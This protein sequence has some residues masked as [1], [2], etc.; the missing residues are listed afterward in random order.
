M[1]YLGDIVGEHVH[2]IHIR[3]EE[4]KLQTPSLLLL[5]YSQFTYLNFLYLPIPLFPVPYYLLP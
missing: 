1:P 5:P 4:K 2:N 3:V